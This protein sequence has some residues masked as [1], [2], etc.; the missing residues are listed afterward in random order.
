MNRHCEIGCRI[1]QSIPELIPISRLIIAHHERWDGN[2][3]PF[4]IKGE[5]IPLECRI[6]AIVDAYDAMTNDRPY[7]KAI[8]Q[9]EAVA[10]LDR[11]AGTQFD[12]VLVAEFIDMMHTRQKS[13][14]S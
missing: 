1:A 8:T 14:V 9:E 5:H 11:C 12:P 10:E 6:L 3:Y 4:G 2:G 13:T 7:R